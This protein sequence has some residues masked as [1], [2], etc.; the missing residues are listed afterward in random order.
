MRGT[1]V[2]GSASPRRARLLSQLGVAFVQR[3]ADIDETPAAGEE[4]R[5]Y[6]ERMAREKSLA[7][8]PEHPGAA[9]LTADTGVILDGRSLGKPV[10]T[11]AAR[12]MLE[13]LSAR[14]HEVCTAVCLA[15]GNQRRQCLV[16]TRVEFAALSEAHIRAYVATDEPWDKAG[17]YAIQGRG[18]AFVRRIDGSVSNVI[19]LPLLETRELLEKLGIALGVAA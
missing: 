2:L 15:R 7:L 19:G 10:D 17:A 13:A 5:R 8:A 3:P 6:V 9:V 1:L 14:E 11:L 16:S 4:P 18:G 12:R